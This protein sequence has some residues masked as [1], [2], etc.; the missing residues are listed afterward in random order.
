MTRRLISLCLLVLGSASLSWEGFA[1]V[2]GKTYDTP[3]ATTT[4]PGAIAETTTSTTYIQN[5]ETALQSMTSGE[6]EVLSSLSRSLVAPRRPVVGGERAEGFP[7][8]KSGDVSLNNRLNAEPHVVGD[9]NAAP[10][11]RGA[12]SEVYF[13]KVQY[14]SFTGE[15]IGARNEAARVLSPGGRHIIETGSAGRRCGPCLRPVRGCGPLRWERRT[16]FASPDVHRRG[17][18]PGAC[19]RLI[20]E[21]GCP[22]YAKS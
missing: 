12:F 18:G 15:N 11:S 5:G 14:S 21:Y 1:S 16:C 6:V 22:G 13:E 10:F 17:S 7:T 9:I 4:T 8:L 19:S 2:L 20:F 3:S